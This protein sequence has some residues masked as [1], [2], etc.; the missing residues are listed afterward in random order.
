MDSMIG[1][2]TEMVDKANAVIRADILYISLAVFII[3]L[4]VVI[5]VIVK[6]MHKLKDEIRSI[7]LRYSEKT[8]EK[9]SELPIEEKNK[10]SESITALNIFLVLG[11]LFGGYYLYQH[12]SKKKAETE[13]VKTEED[14]SETEEDKSQVLKTQP[15]VGI[16]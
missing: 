2:A 8:G 14:K 4:L 16:V 10:E 5:M 6:S 7:K 3:L 11:S 1:K 12:F 15:E 13:E 9:Y